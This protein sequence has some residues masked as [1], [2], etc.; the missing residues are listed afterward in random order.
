MSDQAGSSSP[1]KSRPKSK[2]GAK[3]KTKRTLR[4]V[5]PP[6]QRPVL[7]KEIVETSDDDA[8]EDEDESPDSEGD[9]EGVTPRRRADG[10]AAAT[11]RPGKSFPYVLN[12]LCIQSRPT[13]IVASRRYVP[14]TGMTPITVSTSFQSSLFEYDA[15]ASKPGLELWAIRVPSDVRSPLSRLI[16]LTTAQLKVSRLSSLS[17]TTSSKAPSGTLK[18]KNQSYSLVAAGSSQHTHG[19]VDEEGRQ[20]TAGPGL[21]DAMAMDVDPAEGVMRVEGGEEMSGAMRLLLPRISAG[22][23]LFV[24]ESSRE[25]SGAS[26]VPS[27]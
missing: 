19:V 25:E 27:S 2:S 1:S 5:S 18:T 26:L 3:A 6:A 23:K 8:S 22:G 4:A 16:S 24:G 20:P 17:L 7:S 9:L 13:G 14:P 11:S 15:I 12:N 10:E 21:V